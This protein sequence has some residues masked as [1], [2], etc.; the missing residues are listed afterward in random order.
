[1]N[2]VGWQSAVAGVGFLNASLIQG[3]SALN[4]TSYSPE[5]WQATLMFWAVVIVAVFVNTVLSSLLP[6]VEGLVLI[7]HVLGFFAILIPLV[8][9]GPRGD[10]TH[11]FTIF[12]N[13]GGWP[14]MGISFMVGLVA[15]T[16]NFLGADGAVHVRLSLTHSSAPW[17]TDFLLDV[18]RSS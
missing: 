1:M 5:P 9:M 8:I 3:I 2:V 7:L 14:T 6:K 18:G 15:T 17:P 13:G 11:V 12:V 4:S 10:A 16:W